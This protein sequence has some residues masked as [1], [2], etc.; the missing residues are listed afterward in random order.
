MEDI[1]FRL[2]ASDPEGVRVHLDSTSTLD[3]EAINTE[4][5]LRGFIGAAI[6]DQSRKNRV[7][8]ASS[9]SHLMRIARAANKQLR[10]GT[11]RL[12]EQVVLIGGESFNAPDQIP[13][14][15]RYL[16]TMLHDVFTHVMTTRTLVRPGTNP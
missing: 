4:S 1:F 3:E 14:P 5:N 7:F 10:S 15:P 11:A 8:L 16:K 9:T 2:R 6:L 13:S 12:P